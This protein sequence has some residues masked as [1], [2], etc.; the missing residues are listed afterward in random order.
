MTV[1]QPAHLCDA[2]EHL[3]LCTHLMSFFGAVIALFFTLLFCLSAL[4]HCI[5]FSTYF[6]N[7]AISITALMLIRKV[8]QS[9]HFSDA[10]EYLQ[11]CTI[12]MSIVRSCKRTSTFLF[13]F[14]FLIF[15]LEFFFTFSWSTCSAGELKLCIEQPRCL[16]HTAWHF[17]LQ[18]SYKLFFSG[19]QHHEWAQLP[20][21]G[22]ADV[23]ASIRKLEAETDRHIG[24][25][26]DRK[27]KEKKNKK[28]I[29]PARA[30]RRTSSR[31]P[32]SMTKGPWPM[33]DVDRP[34]EL[35]NGIVDADTKDGSST[36][37]TRSTVRHLPIIALER[38]TPCLSRAFNSTA[39][40]KQKQ[41]VPPQQRLL[42]TADLLCKR[43]ICFFYFQ[44][45]K[46]YWSL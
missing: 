41:E 18:V 32:Q 24:T 43:A 3:Q 14:F 10:T 17:I 26:G 34:A 29:G 8:L 35:W 42:K 21:A 25:L 15:A 9:A 37:P 23:P 12:L 22:R 2:T 30:P 6:S 40:T 33:A 20:D 11:P 16:K 44:T 19:K 27:M 5:F 1:P 46:K 31:A 4:L 13:F 28:L 38:R 45:W 7:F 39:L 36:Y